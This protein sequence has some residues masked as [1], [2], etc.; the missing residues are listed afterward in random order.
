MSYRKIVLIE[1]RASLWPLVTA[2]CPGRVPGPY[3]TIVIKLSLLVVGTVIRMS[4][5]TAGVFL[6][7]KKTLVPKI[8]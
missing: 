1:V 3:I 8:E 6:V 4:F 2:F 7:R 5:S